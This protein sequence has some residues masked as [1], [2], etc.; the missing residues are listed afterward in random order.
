V[1]QLHG[2]A[3]LVFVAPHALVHWSG[4]QREKG[5]QQREDE[6][7]EEGTIN[8]IVGANLRHGRFVAQEVVNLA[9]PHI[10]YHHAVRGN[11]TQILQGLFHLLMLNGERARS[12]GAR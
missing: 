12:S 3:L 11:A 8:D 1:Q 10:G 7:R 5:R 4:G 6:E 2:K 9:M